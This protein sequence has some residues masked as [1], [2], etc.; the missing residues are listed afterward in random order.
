MMIR[1]NPRSI[2]PL[3]RVRVPITSPRNQREWIDHRC[4]PQVWPTHHLLRRVEGTPIHPCTPRRAAP[5]RRTHLVEVEVILLHTP[6]RAQ[7]VHHRDTHRQAVSPLPHR[8]ILLLVVLVVVRVVLMDCRPSTHHHKPQRQQIEVNVLDQ[9][10]QQP[11]LVVRHTLLT[12]RPMLEVGV[13]TAR[14]R[15]KRMM[16]P[17][18]QSTLP[19]SRKTSH[20]E[21][22]PLE[23]RRAYLWSRVLG[24]MQVKVRM[25]LDPPSCIPRIIPV[26]CHIVQ[27]IV[28]FTH[29]LQAHHWLRNL[30]PIPQLHP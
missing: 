8:R 1:R 11:T 29:R 30:R 13:C 16:I 20:L 9:G 18:L 28:M 10:P 23:A 6:R 5:Q 22:I 2:P 4:I 27:H 26:L 25:S 12:H 7:G 21:H 24:I 15:P 3:M 14:L 19:R 17:N